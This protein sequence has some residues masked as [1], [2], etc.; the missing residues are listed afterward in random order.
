MIEAGIEADLA[1]AFAI[2]AAL[3]KAAVEGTGTR[4][5][6]S[7]LE[8]AFSLLAV[9]HGTRRGDFDAPAPRPAYDVYQAADGR[10]VAIG[11][12]RP[13]SCGALF[14]HLG[15]ADLAERGLV[16]GDAEA[17][18]FLRAA[19][20]TKPAD[21]WVEALG[22]LDI[23]VSLVRSP[24]EAFDDPQ[25]LARGMISESQHPLAGTLRQMNGFFRP[26]SPELAPAPSIGRDTDV[27]LAELGYDMEA[28]TALRGP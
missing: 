8:A 12:A 19:I 10:H 21:E 6:L 5:D 11:A 17:A 16:P 9:S 26:E 18:A 2:T 7:M 24:A 13:A 4:I 25:L 22:A 23:E 28:I 14:Q 15:R 27:V 20:A 1:A 3:R